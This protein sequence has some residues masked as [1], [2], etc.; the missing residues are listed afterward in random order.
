[1]QRCADLGVSARS[2]KLGRNHPRVV[3]HQAIAR[4]QQ[5]REVA[6]A[7]VRYRAAIDDEHARRVTRT[8]RAE[9]DALGRQV[10]IEGVDAHGVRALARAYCWIGALSWSAVIGAAGAA[11]GGVSVS[12]DAGGIGLLSAA[13][14]T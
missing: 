11:A 1:M 8:R 10:K 9:R 12:I 5:R 2:F 6:H 7:A 13:T 3:E 14:D 4:A